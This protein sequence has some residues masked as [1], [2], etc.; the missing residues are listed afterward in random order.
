MPTATCCGTL[1]VDS[2]FIWIPISQIVK[3]ERRHVALGSRRFEQ[4]ILSTGQP[5]FA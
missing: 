1:Q 2:H 5:D 4:L 3:R